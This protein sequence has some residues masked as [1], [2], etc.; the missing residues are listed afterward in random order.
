[1]IS[2]QYLWVF[3]VWKL[4]SFT[5]DLQHIRNR[6]VSSYSPNAKH[7]V[8][9]QSYGLDAICSHISYHKNL[10]MVQL[11]VW[12]LRQLPSQSIDK[13]SPKGSFR[14]TVTSCLD[15]PEQLQVNLASIHNH[16]NTDEEQMNWISKFS[17]ENSRAPYPEE[18][19]QGGVAGAST[20][21]RVTNTSRTSNNI[22]SFR[23]G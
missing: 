8:S 6:G 21:S 7:G 9:Q 22:L 5:E 17:W 15:D 14:R 3:S 16:F 23:L 18:Y 12:N 11:C 4:D 20:F 10:G 19:N 13:G 1:M 2:L